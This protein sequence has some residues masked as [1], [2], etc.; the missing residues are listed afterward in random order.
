MHLDPITATRVVSLNSPSDD[1]KM[2][3]ETALFKEDRDSVA[4]DGALCVAFDRTRTPLYES[5]PKQ[6]FRNFSGNRSDRTVINGS[7]QTV[8]KHEIIKIDCH[9]SDSALLLQCSH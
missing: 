6:V 9:C 7:R 8:H 5:P 1:E 4:F 2:D 3:T